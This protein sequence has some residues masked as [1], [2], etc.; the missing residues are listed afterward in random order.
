MDVWTVIGYLLLG[1]ILGAVGQC[2]RVIVGLKK[3]HDEAIQK[4]K[5]FKELFDKE[6]MWTS[7]LI[8]FI[9]GVAA[10]VLGIINFMGQ[11]I[12]PQFILTLI[13]IGYVGTDFIEG[14][15]IKKAYQKTG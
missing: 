8:A 9:V 13:G 5:S 15:L 12:T 2:L 6:K 11:E 7:F 10:G 4:G 3:R 1:G 14:L